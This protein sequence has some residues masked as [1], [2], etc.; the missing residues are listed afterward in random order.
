[1]HEIE[2]VRS[3]LSKAEAEVDAHG[4]SAVRG[5]FLRVGSMSGVDVEL[6]L[7]AYR[8][9]RPSTFCE[10]ADLTVEVVQAH[11][12][13]PVCGDLGGPAGSHLACPVCGDPLRL[14]AGDELVLERLELEVAD[15]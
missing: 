7:A 13:C 12:V 8:R 6:L 9:C 2:L 10:G 5:V 1:M 15:E 4:A 14:T 11:W 3:L